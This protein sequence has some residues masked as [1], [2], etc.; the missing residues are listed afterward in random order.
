MANVGSGLVGQTLIGDGN[1]SGPKYANIGTNSGLT[2]H[3]VVIAEGNGAFSSS[4]AGTNG[5]VLAS[6]GVSA[7]PTFKTLS[8]IGALT[9]LNG[10]SGT[11]TPSGGAIS[12]IT[13]NATPKFVGSGSTLTLDFGLTNIIL[14]SS[15]SITSGTSN[16]GLGD[17][18]LAAT[19]VGISN[20]A[21]GVSSMQNNTTGSSCTALGTS[22]LTSFNPGGVIVVQ[23]LNTCV[24]FSALSQLV[25]GIYNTVMGPQSGINYTTSESSNVLISNAGTISESNV[26]RIGTQG[27]GNGQQNK[28]FLAGVTGVTV[29]GTAPVGVDTN[30]QFSSLGFGTSTQVLTSNG[31]STSPTWQA[32][33][34]FTPVNWSVQ[35]SGNISNVTGDGTTYT[36]LYD[37]TN[38]NN[39]GGSYAAGTGIYTFPATGVYQINVLNFLFGGGVA[40]TVIIG[41]LLINGATNVRLFDANPGSLG[42]TVN[43]EFMQSASFLYSAAAFATIRVQVAVNGGTK[44]VGVAGGTQTCI[45]S[46]FRVS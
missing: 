1:G 11:A 42:L 34:F 12:V 31:A 17:F 6:N 46:G 37:T 10:N 35:L 4:T 43:G 7:D 26:I 44:N 21:A 45:F 36:I 20:T 15:G 25:S 27:S 28:A 29:T 9:S 14:G 38:F 3:G 24:G 32:T 39:G 22:S 33:G 16:S 8:S 19:N 30:G 23:A 2:L 5:Q 13:A 18:V 40:D 41:N